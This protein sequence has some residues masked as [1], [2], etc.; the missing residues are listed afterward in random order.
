MRA[1]L[2]KPGLFLNEELGRLPV[3]A[4]YL[5]AGL[6]CVADREGRLE[7]RPERLK[8]EIFPYDKGQAKVND[9]LDR[10][11]LAGFI[12]RY[13]VD[14]Q[15]LICLPSFTKH[16]HPHPNEAASHLVMCP[17]DIA[18]KCNCITCNATRCQAV[19][20]N[21]D[22]SGDHSGDQDDDGDQGVVIVD[23]LFGVACSL[24]ENEI[25]SL[26][27]S[28]SEQLKA[29]VDDYPNRRWIEEAFKIA[30]ANGKRNLGY[31]KGILKNY[32]TDG[33]HAEEEERDDVDEGAVAEFRRKHPEIFAGRGGRD[34]P[35][36]PEPEG[37]GAG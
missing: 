34:N 33:F 29:L 36:L 18:V 37:E 27:E 32:Q 23:E 9:L 22:H 35:P 11:A 26:S 24:Y 14:G 5:F 17:P 8:A 3:A 12:V 2:L 7:D 6:W 28:A 15:H 19:I 30:V 10:L 1:R 20:N 4:R 16:Q 21:G 13:E 31:I 25:H